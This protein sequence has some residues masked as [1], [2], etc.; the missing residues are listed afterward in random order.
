[1]KIKLPVSLNKHEGQARQEK[2][3][4]VLGDDSLISQ[5]RP[6]TRGRRAS[7]FSQQSL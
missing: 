3:R 6:Q 4:W 1:L 7:V 5:H 2:I